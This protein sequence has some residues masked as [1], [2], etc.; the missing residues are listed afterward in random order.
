MFYAQPSHLYSIFNAFYRLRAFEDVQ[1]FW[2][3]TF[4]EEIL[5]L[6]NNGINLAGELVQTSGITLCKR[7]DVICTLTLEIQD[8][9]VR[10]IHFCTSVF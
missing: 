6:T 9:E 7:G 1:V 2:R 10:G 5:S 3:V 4:S 8:D